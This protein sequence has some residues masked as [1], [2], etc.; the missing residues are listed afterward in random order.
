MRADDGS[1]RAVFPN[2]ERQW[3]EASCSDMY[4]VRRSEV[5]IACREERSVSEALAAAKRAYDLCRPMFVFELV[6]D[7]L[8]C[9]SRSW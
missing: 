7:L 4:L 2:H 6:E 8:G 5:A 3:K 9:G 1:E